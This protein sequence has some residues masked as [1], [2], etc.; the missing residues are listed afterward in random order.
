MSE[1]QLGAGWTEHNA[2]AVAEAAAIP[3][4]VCG[5]GVTY[6]QSRHVVC[7]N[8]MGGLKLIIEGRF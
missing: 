1:L 8:M 7:V 6:C 2:A 5:G 4:A 3:A